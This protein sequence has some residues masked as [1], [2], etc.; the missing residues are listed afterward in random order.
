MRAHGRNELG[1]RR[2]RI[3]VL[4]T[5]LLPLLVTIARVHL[6]SRNILLVAG[7]VEAAAADI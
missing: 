7:F 5:A 6:C 2:T 1:R 3:D 4:M